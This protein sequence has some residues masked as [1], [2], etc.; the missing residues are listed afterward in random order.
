VSNGQLKPAN[1]K[2][3]SCSYVYELSLNEK[4]A[5][6]PCSD[7]MAAPALRYELVPFDALGS[8]LGS[9]A[10]VDVLGVVTHCGDL[11]SV[12]RKSDGAALARRDLTLLDATARTVK[13]TLWNTLA[14]QEGADIAAR[15]ATAPPIIAVKGVR[16]SDYNGVSLSTVAR[17]MLAVEPTELPATAALRTWYAAGGASA[18]TTEAGAGYA[19][20]R[21]TGATAGSA[22]R[23]SFADVQP[24]TLAVA[25]AKPEWAT[26]C[27]CVVHIAPDAA[28]YYTACPEEGCNKKVVQD[29]AGWL[30]E[31]SGKR[32]DA[33]KRRYILR[34]K[35]ADATGAGWVN[36]FDDQARQVFGCTAEELHTLK[37]AGDAR[38]AR[39]LREAQWRLWV[40]KVKTKT[41][42]YNGE[43]R[44]RIT[45]VALSKPDY[46]A[47]CKQLVA[48]IAAC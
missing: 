41:E 9:R 46:A 28:L 15:C 26:L 7:A 12:A 14:E 23:A 30:C 29:G 45:A 5:V 37:E 19:G 20:A 16:V 39:T 47:Q 8:K 24:E 13:L 27:G 4:T 42:E 38:Y 33:C 34:F 35:A 44:R 31:A 32:F 1:L 17:S 11:G 40:M 18:P 22:P 6:E 10:T 43:A 48:A 3:S 2:F 21:G 25:D 36:A